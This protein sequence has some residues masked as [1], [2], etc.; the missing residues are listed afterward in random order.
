MKPYPA[1]GLAAVAALSLSGGVGTGHLT[2]NIRVS[3]AASEADRAA[4]LSEAS[5]Q[6]DEWSLRRTY[7]ECLIARGYAVRIKEPSA[8]GV[9]S[10][11]VKSSSPI[12]LVKVTDDF[13]A[14]A[15]AAYPGTF[16]SSQ[17]FG[18]GMFGIWNQWDPVPD[19]VRD[20]YLECWRSRGYEAREHEEGA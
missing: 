19:D 13:E 16:S 6:H 18:G 2:K 7:M 4:C 15:N 1:V 11:V 12:T 17:A 3:P 5:T 9:M 10:V 14:C 8:R 20:R